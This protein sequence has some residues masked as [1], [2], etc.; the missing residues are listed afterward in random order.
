MRVED[1]C[2]LDENRYVV[3]HSLIDS[4][5]S[6][7]SIVRIVPMLKFDRLIMLLHNR[8]VTVRF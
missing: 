7:L 4:Q 2:I 3:A 5:I 8:L 1:A 6:I